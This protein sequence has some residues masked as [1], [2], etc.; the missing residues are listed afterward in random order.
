ML[1]LSFLV[2]LLS[3]EK[4]HGNTNNE[5]KQEDEKN[6]SDDYELYWHQSERIRPLFN[7]VDSVFIGITV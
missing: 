3:V 7:R 2:V 1:F 4:V 6:N 5:T